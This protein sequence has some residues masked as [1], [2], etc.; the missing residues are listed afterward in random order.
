MPYVRLHQA[1]PRAGYS[2]ARS[3][4]RIDGPRELSRWFV[5]GWNVL[6][7]RSAKRRRIVV[8]RRQGR[9]AGAARRRIARLRRQTIEQDRGHTRVMALDVPAAG[10]AS[11]GVGWAG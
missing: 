2:Q 4:P 10:V 9:H 8:G 6:S 11:V 1:P 7:D 3:P 5:N